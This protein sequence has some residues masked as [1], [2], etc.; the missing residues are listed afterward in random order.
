TFSPKPSSSVRMKK[1][2]ERAK[3][4]VML[5]QTAAIHTNLPEW[6]ERLVAQKRRGPMHHPK[7][8]RRR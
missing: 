8:H 5:S 6:F 1:E 4:A 3:I 7:R 2:L